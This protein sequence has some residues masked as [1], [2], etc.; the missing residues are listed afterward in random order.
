[1]RMCNAE[2][3]IRSATQ[4][5]N[6]NEDDITVW[7]RYIRQYEPR[8]HSRLSSSSCEPKSRSTRYHIMI[9][10]VPDIRLDHPAFLVAGFRLFL[11]PVSGRILEMTSLI[12]GFHKGR[13]SRQNIQLRGLQKTGGQKLSSHGNLHCCTVVYCEKIKSVNI[14]FH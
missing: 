13:I 2:S 10:D 4:G 8:S 11:W 12:S 9:R 1:M 3:Q 7:C 5:S 14:Y 6:F